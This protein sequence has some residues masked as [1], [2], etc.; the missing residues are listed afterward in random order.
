MKTINLNT[1]N[2]F[3]NAIIKG[4]LKTVKNIFS[5]INPKRYNINSVLKIAIDK[6]QLSIAK[7]AIENGAVVDHWV[8]NTNNICK[9]NIDVVVFL[10]ENGG[11]ISHLTDNFHLDYGNFAWASHLCADKRLLAYLVS[12]GFDINFANGFLLRGVLV[13]FNSYRYEGE[14]YQKIL[15]LLDLGADLNVLDTRL[16]YAI[17]SKSIRMIEYWINNLNLAFDVQ[18]HHAELNFYTFEFE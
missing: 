18:H 8:V 4:D 6:K 2:I 13:W 17:E 10:L 11:R 14:N 12:K 16:K 15:N 1:E 3:V 9:N 5:E 7:W